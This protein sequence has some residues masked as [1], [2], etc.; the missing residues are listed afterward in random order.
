M[1]HSQSPPENGSR[2]LDLP[3]EIRLAIYEFLPKTKWL[4]RTFMDGSF[5]ALDMTYDMS[6]L[7]V[8][9]LVHSEA[10]P[11][12]QKAMQIPT[13]TPTFHLVRKRYSVGALLANLGELYFVSSN[14]R[15]MFSVFSSDAALDKYGCRT[16][17]R[18]APG[19]KTTFR[20]DYELP[21]PVWSRKLLSRCSSELAILEVAEEKGIIVHVVHGG[22]TMP[23]PEYLSTMNWPHYLETQRWK[24]TWRRPVRSHHIL[25]WIENVD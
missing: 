16:R 20:I 21:P 1:E 17:L 22:T 2:S 3:T 8:C 14:P 15:S 7:C 13:N 24:N 18:Q 5:K 10:L 11:T 19:S 25:G 4:T 12:I 6:I 23:L 9:R